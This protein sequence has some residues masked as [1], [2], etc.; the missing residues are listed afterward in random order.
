MKTKLVTNHND[1]EGL[2][3]DGKLV[4]EGHSIS[5]LDFARATGI[6][7]EQVAVSTEWLGET[8]GN[9]PKSFGKIPS[10][11]IVA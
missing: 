6:D 9:L 2:Y 8:V 4:I 1:W 10:K 7:L 5:L 3:I 11:H